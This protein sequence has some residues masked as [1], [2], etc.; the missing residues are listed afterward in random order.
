MAA[1]KTTDRG[2]TYAVVDGHGNKA[3]LTQTQATFV[4]ASPTVTL[5]VGGNTVT[6]TK[7]N[8]ADLLAPFTG[9][10]STGV[11]S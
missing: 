5:T 3:T 4:G 8:V 1:A 9:F 11:L 10:S 6:L 7:Q 2:I